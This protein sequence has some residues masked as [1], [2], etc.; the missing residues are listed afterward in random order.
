ML[1]IGVDFKIQ[2]IHYTMK[3]DDIMEEKKI[4]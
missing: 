3:N 4:E 1:N 2:I